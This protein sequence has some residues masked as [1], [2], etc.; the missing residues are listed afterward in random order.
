MQGVE[1]F[2]KIYLAR[3]KNIANLA[4]ISVVNNIT[5]IL[6]VGANTG[7][8]TRAMTTYF[9]HSS[10]LMIEGNEEMIPQL[11]GAGH[12]Y[13]ISLVGDERKDV[14]FHVHKTYSTGGSIYKEHG[15]K[16]FNADKI[17]SDTLSMD[18]IDNIVT[19]EGFEGVDLLKMDI[20]G[21][22]YIALQGA[23]ETLKTTQLVLLE[24]AIHQYNPGS[25]GFT[26]INAFLEN[27]GFR[28]YDIVDL[29]YDKHLYNNRGSGLL[30]V[31]MLWAKSNSKFFTTSK[32]PMPPPNL[33]ECELKP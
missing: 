19:R 8:W 4:D 29:R 14:T 11:K 20:Q 7:H 15:Y 2:S 30:Q 21:A 9:P 32:F 31:D 6:D 18:T 5:N 27:H 24:V 23:Q 3:M 1:V 33:Y 17:R 13:V 16:N 10:F 26:D 28:L 22:E 12:K 25:P